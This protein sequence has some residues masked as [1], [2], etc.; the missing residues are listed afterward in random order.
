MNFY[1]EKKLYENDMRILA[2]KVDL[3]TYPAHWHME[4]EI[5]AV[6]S[7]NIKV[8]FNMQTYSVSAGELI[9][10]PG[11]NIHYYEFENAGEGCYIVFSPEILNDELNGFSL[12]LYIKNNIEF[13]IEIFQYIV[14]EMKKRRTAYEDFVNSYLRLISA[15]LVRIRT[16]QNIIS[17][18]AYTVDL[19][20]IKILLE[21][22][23][24]NYSQ[25]I[26]VSTG[27]NMLHFSENYFNKYFKTFCGTTFSKYVNFIRIKAAKKMLKT[28]NMKIIEIATNS[29]FENVR[30]FN[31]EFKALTGITA[32]EYRKI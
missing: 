30:T 3:N 26:T 11:G 20:K 23:E 6:L 4:H 16:T 28:T 22:I 19:Q 1:H 5:I 8:G 29:G 2:E 9:F 25:R 7:G 27:S 15:L 32:K 18:V 17:K 31:R 14:D 12:P 21:Y 24:E 10:I 13:Y